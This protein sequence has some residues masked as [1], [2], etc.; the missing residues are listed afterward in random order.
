MVNVMSVKRMCVGFVLATIVQYL[1]REKCAASRLA[2]M[3]SGFFAERVN[4]AY[5]QQKRNNLVSMGFLV[6]DLT[7]NDGKRTQEEL[8]IWV[9]MALGASFFINLILFKMTGSCSSLENV[10]IMTFLNYSVG[11][12]LSSQSLIGLHK[13]IEQAYR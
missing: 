2:F 11:D 12:Y 7:F 9:C 8:C 6:L 13:K 1:G 5:I 10:A 3:A 4:I